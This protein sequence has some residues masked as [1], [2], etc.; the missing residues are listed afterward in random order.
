MICHVFYCEKLYW[1]EFF[2]VIY[3][4]NKP[5]SGIVVSNEPIKCVAEQNIT[6]LGVFSVKWTVPQLSIMIIY[7]SSW[8]IFIQWIRVMIVR[9]QSA[10]VHTKES[11]LP[12]FQKPYYSNKRNVQK[13]EEIAVL[14][15]CVF[16]KC[17]NCLLYFRDN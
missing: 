17:S 3:C 2:T 11:V 7:N 13:G 6:E 12:V 10:L 4:Y 15:N 1:S 8:S 14:R 9:W 5:I 16:L